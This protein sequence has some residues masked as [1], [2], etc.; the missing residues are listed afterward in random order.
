MTKYT[1]IVQYVFFI[2]FLCNYFFIL[3]TVSQR[4]TD[5]KRKHFSIGVPGKQTGGGNPTKTEVVS[6][7][8][9]NVL[10]IDDY[11]N[12]KSIYVYD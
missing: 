9:Y 8:R 6:T 2:I 10:N 4:R 12:H 11:R 5:K 3:V 1:V 7:R